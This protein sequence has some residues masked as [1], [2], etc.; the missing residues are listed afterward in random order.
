MA[1]HLPRTTKEG[2]VLLTILPFLT[3]PMERRRRRRRDIKVSLDFTLR[4]LTAILLLWSVKKISFSAHRSLIA[5]P[6]SMNSNTMDFSVISE[7]DIDPRYMSLNNKRVRHFVQRCPSAGIKSHDPKDVKMPV[8]S[9]EMGGY[10]AVK[11]KQKGVN[12]KW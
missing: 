2:Q 7:S 8:R 1:Q 3:R 11:C 10:V 6:C 9:K 5:K 4:K 12:G